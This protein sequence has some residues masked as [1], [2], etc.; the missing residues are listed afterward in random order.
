MVGSPRTTRNKAGR[1]RRLPNASGAARGATDLPVHMLSGRA[2]QGYL[3][4]PQDPRTLSNFPT[5][6]G[7]QRDNH[8]WIFA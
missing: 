7:I 6:A 4:D 5:L 1:L 3:P 2:A 8:E